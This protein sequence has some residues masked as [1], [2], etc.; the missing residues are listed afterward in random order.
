MPTYNE[1]LVANNLK[2]DEITAIANSL[3]DADVIEAKLDAQDEIIENLKEALEEKASPPEGAKIFISAQDMQA[4]QNPKQKGLAAIYAT[5]IEDLVEGE[6]VYGFILPKNVDL[7]EPLSQ[8]GYADW[9]DSTHRYTFSFNASTTLSDEVYKT[10]LEVTMYYPLDTYYYDMTEPE[11]EPEPTDVR[12]IQ[13]KAIWTSSDKQNYT[14]TTFTKTINTYGGSGTPEPIEIDTLNY[15]DFPFKIIPVFISKTV[16]T[17]LK[18]ISDFVKYKNGK[19]YGMYQYGHNEFAGTINCLNVVWTNG[20]QKP[21]V[22]VV[23]NNY[24]NYEKIIS[25]L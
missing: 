23:E 10:T 18:P 16:T 17:G 14:L 5:S 6:G 15:I 22:Q 4:D 9:G 7:G 3:P 21:T 20:T 19:F 13:Y 24:V 1:R 2:I 25:I 11:P 8:D 12:S